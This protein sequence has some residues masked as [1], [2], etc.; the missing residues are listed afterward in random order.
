MRN[1]EVAGRLSFEISGFPEKRLKYRLTEI[2]KLRRNE[3]MMEKL[4]IIF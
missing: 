1:G 3:E 2:R 4:T